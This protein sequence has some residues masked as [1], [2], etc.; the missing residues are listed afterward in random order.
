MEKKKQKLLRM[1]Y[2]GGGKKSNGKAKKMLNEVSS[3]VWWIL[4]K[5]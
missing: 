3:S 5:N 1:G 4:E 2:D